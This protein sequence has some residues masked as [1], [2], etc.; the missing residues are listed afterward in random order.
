MNRNY[1]TYN[2]GGHNGG[3]TPYKRTFTSG[4]GWTN[5]NNNGR[6]MTGNSNERFLAAYNRLD[7]FLQS[8]VRTK[9]R[10]NMIWHLEQISP[11]EKRSKIQTVRQFKNVIASHGVNPGF[12]APTVPEVWIS[13]LLGEL[14]WCK[15][16]SARIAPK[17]QK[18][19]DSTSKEPRNSK[20]ANYRQQTPKTEGYVVYIVN[21]FGRGYYFSGY[22]YD[23]VRYGFLNVKKDTVRS[24]KQE[25]DKS[26]ARVYPTR[27]AAEFVVNKLK[28]E[29]P[30]AYI[31][32]VKAA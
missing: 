21:S 6:K 12:V 25:T 28:K 1:Q 7:N 15:K 8:I 4:N 18:V 2:N 23:T 32:V 31:S 26:K 29:Q 10:V 17:L 5:Q 9:Y 16:N 27:S 14:E 3:Y 13:W 19:L 11:E 24:L 30:R 22:E 20:G